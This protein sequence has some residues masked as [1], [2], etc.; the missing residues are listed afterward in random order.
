MHA[1]YRIGQRY[2][3]PLHGVGEVTAIDHEVMRV[4]LRGIVA[5]IDFHCRP[6]YYGGTLARTGAEQ[7]LKH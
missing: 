5:Y 2:Y 4:D 1:Q 3:F 6:V 7:T